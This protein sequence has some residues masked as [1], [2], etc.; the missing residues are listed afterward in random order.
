MRIRYIIFTIMLVIALNGYSQQ[1]PIYSQ[2]MVNKF[3]LNPAIAGSTGYTFINMAAREQYS[4]FTNAP[5]TFSLSG[6]TR[7]LNDSY[8]RRHLPVRKNV[9]NATRDTR[10]GLGGHIYNDRNGIV[11]RTGLQLTYA[12]HIN[13]NNKIQLSM[14]LTASGY[15]FK[16]DDTDTYVV[17]PEDPVLS[18]ERKSFFVP[19]A[20]FG[21]YLTDNKF[22][23]GLSMTDVLGSSLK[24]GK[25]NIKDNFRTI[26]HYSLIGGYKFK[27]ENGLSFEPSALLRT[28]RLISQLDLSVKTSY[29]DDYW[30]GFSYRT[31]KT[32][33]TMIGL[34]V[35]MF[36][37][38]YA[39]D[40]SFGS[41]SNY[42][43]G[44]HEIMTGVRF[45]DNSTRRFRWLRKDAVNY[46]L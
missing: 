22:Y 33:I 11:S 23:A 44:S 14:G 24:L 29:M 9:N 37:F 19:D 41:I 26:R 39:Y 8:I 25:D 6:Q 34:N 17:S 20:S 16:M 27:L 43:S 2:Y 4:G 45:G 13:F 42:S 10:V 3:L 40:A 21:M 35:D 12:Y 32:F 15:Q 28:T 46:E 5:R 30:L 7:L 18:G 31:N 36:Y 1:S 38:G